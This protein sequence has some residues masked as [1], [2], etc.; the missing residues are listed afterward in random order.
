[1]IQRFFLWAAIKYLKITN[2]PMQKIFNYDWISDTITIYDTKYSAQI[3]RDWSRKGIPLN[4]RF[5]LLDISE[6]EG[7]VIG[8]G[9]LG[10]SVL[11]T[12]YNLVIFNSIG[13]IISLLKNYI[14]VSYPF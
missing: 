3:F 2:Y 4:T 14:I 10:F 11:E 6:N 9:F 12:V 7:K 8:L 1:M 13:V 5:L